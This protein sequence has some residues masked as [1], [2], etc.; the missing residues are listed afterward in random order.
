[1][2]NA[3]GDSIPISPDTVG[4]ELHNEATK[5]RSALVRWGKAEAVPDPM[6]DAE[7]KNWLH[8]DRCGS[9]YRAGW[10]HVGQR[11]GDVDQMDPDRQCD[12]LLVED[13]D[14]RTKQ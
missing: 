10:F 8:C 6:I 5:L 1:M 11:C 9:W 12:G 13:I 14:G 2:E 3:T 7:Q 4:R